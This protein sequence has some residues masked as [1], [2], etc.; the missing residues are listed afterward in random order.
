[1]TQVQFA[2]H[3]AF[4]HSTHACYFWFWLLWLLLL[5][6]VLVL[7]RSGRTL[8]T[9]PTCQPHGVWIHTS[10][11]RVRMK[12][13]WRRCVSTSERRDLNSLEHQHHMILLLLMFGLAFLPE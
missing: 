12:T 8:I 10:I 9:A 5:L 4:L 6:L 11:R 1:M 3:I 13:I 2:V 7:C